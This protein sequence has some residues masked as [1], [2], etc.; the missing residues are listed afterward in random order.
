MRSGSL[1]KNAL[2]IPEVSTPELSRLQ[3]K[4]KSIT[5]I[6]NS[7][8]KFGNSSSSANLQDQDENRMFASKESL[9]SIDTDYTLQFVVCIV[10]HITNLKCTCVGIKSDP[11]YNNSRLS[12][13]RTP[14]DCRY[15]QFLFVLSGKR[16]YLVCIS[17]GEE[18]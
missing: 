6:A 8:K 14:G 10:Y 15:L 5:N 9:E 13:I 3:K 2:N 17:L 12:L 4:T 18:N 1:S 11:D 16:N 7:S